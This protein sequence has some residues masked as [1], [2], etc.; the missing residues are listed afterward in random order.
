MKSNKVVVALYDFRSK[1][2][3]IYR[4]N[5]IREISGASELIAHLYREF[6]EECEKTQKIKI[7][8]SLEKRFELKQVLDGFRSDTLD[9]QI[10]YEGGGN[11]YLLYK[12]YETYCSAN[13]IFSRL[14]IEKSYSLN[15]LVSHI[16]VAEEELDFN[17][18]LQDVYAENTK[19]KNIEFV[20]EPLT[21]L[22]Y[23]QVDP[24]TFSPIVKKEN[25]ISYTKESIKKQCAYEAYAQGKNGEDS[26]EKIAENDGKNSLLAIIY[27]DGNGIGEKLQQ[28]TDEA[29]SYDDCVAKMREFSAT[30]KDVFVTR[31]MKAIQECLEKEQKLNEYRQVVGGGDEITIICNAHVALKIAKAYFDALDEHYHAGM[32]IAICHAKAPF[33]EVYK[34]AEACAESAKNKDRNRNC[35]DWHFCRSGITND[36]DVLRDKQEA[37]ITNRPYV[38]DPDFET[39]FSD[40]ELVKVLNRTDIKNL[41]G[42]ILDGDSCYSME[43]ERLKSKYPKHLDKALKVYSTEQEQK[44]CIFDIAGMYDLWLK[45]EK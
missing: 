1:Q 45:P 19:K 43:L 2:E 40:S 4:T 17:K 44:K 14:V 35:I 38:V 33:Y 16:E 24:V 26:L 25:G 8:H 12:D 30:I 11:L 21:V 9:A 10:I 39:K 5:K 27:T 23:T 18:N 13:K 20:S 15:M 37:E 31:P 36:F 42:F 3:Y 6:Y 41:G 22:P 28:V 7:E 34:I 32:G 29:Q